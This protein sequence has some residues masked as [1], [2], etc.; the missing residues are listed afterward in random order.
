MPKIYWISNLRVF[1]TLIVILLHT[2]S[3]GVYHFGK[4]P[5]DTWWICNII[6]TFGRFAVPV[7]VM[8]SGYLLLDRYDDLG[9]FLSKRFS[10]IFVPFLVWLFIYMIHG[11]FKGIKAEQV[12]W[13]S[14]D[15]LVRIL[16]NNASGSGQL[17]FVYMLLGLYLFTPILSRWFVAAPKNEVLFF[18]GMWF[19]ANSC[20]LVLEKT[21]NIKPYFDFRYFTGFAGYFVLGAY[22]KK[23]PILPSA[24]TLLL[25]IALFLIGWISTMF[26]VEFFSKQAGKY[27]DLLG[28]H[29]PLVVMMSFGIVLFFQ[30]IF[31]K[32]F[33]EKAIGEIDASSYG[34]F[35]FHWLVMKILSRDFKINFAMY[36]NPI[37]GML[38]HFILT[39]VICIVVIGIIRRLP[40]G[41]WITG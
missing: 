4:M 30:Q 5:V 2:A 27:I 39:A 15:W 7:F 22:L 33:A 40:K 14:A 32:P 12:N 18:L 37:P 26:T 20:F 31:N 10:R 35:L 8:L 11:T 1:A 38:L 21:M 41:H 17:W 34:V 23:Y 29:S 28:Y 3:N 24:Q 25:A 19:V 6:N 36:K 16:T 13:L 9:A